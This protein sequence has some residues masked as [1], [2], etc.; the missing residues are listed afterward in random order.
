MRESIPAGF[1][2]ALLNGATAS[3]GE[4]CEYKRQGE[5]EEENDVTTETKTDRSD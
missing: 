2:G 3:L 5:G 1:L 4:R